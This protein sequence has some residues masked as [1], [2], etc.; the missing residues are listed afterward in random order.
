M[1]KGGMKGI[2]SG[3]DLLP[4]RF[5][6]GPD[7]G[8]SIIRNLPWPDPGDLPQRIKSSRVQRGLLG[9]GLGD[10][11]EAS[12]LANVRGEKEAVR[13]AMETKACKG[14]PSIKSQD[15]S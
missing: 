4:I 15:W 10:G 6:L 7:P 13:K 5:F 3:R 11:I 8:E 2:S 12:E 9:F 1:S 14:S